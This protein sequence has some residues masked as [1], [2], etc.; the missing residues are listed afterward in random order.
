MA[1]E[2]INLN[3]GNPLLSITILCSFCLALLFPGESPFELTRDSSLAF[4]Q[5]SQALQNVDARLWQDPFKVIEEESSKENKPD[6]TIELDQ[7]KNYFTE[8]ELKSSTFEVMMITLSGGNRSEDSESRMR[9]RFAV[10]SALIHNEYL[11]LDNK[12]IGAINPNQSG[13]GLKKRIPFEI[14]KKKEDED[15][16]RIVLWIDED[17]LNAPMPLDNNKNNSPSIASRLLEINNNILEALNGHDQTK[18]SE[19]IVIGPNSSDTMQKITREGV[20]NCQNPDSKGQSI[21]FL[22][23][24]ATASDEIIRGKHA[25]LAIKRPYN[26]DDE[27]IQKL[28]EELTLEGFKSDDSIAIFKE[29]DTLYGRSMETYVR[30]K[31]KDNNKIFISYFKGVNDISSGNEKK[32][33]EKKDTANASIEHSFG[34][35]QIDYIRREVLKLKQHHPDLKAIGV[36]GNEIND[37]LLIIE[38]IR[39]EFPHIRIITTDLDAEYLHPDLFKYTHN[40]IIASSFG[41]NPEPV[42]PSA[43]TQESQ[44][45]QNAPTFRDSYQTAFYVTVDHAIKKILG[46]YLDD[47][48]FE[49]KLYEV[50]KGEFIDLNYHS[51][52]K[53]KRPENTKLALKFFAVVI[54]SILLISVLSWN[55]RQFLNRN[56]KSLIIIGLVMMFSISLYIFSTSLPEPFLLLSGASTWPSIILRLLVIVVAWLAIKN[57]GIKSKL[58]KLQYEY[59]LTES[60]NSRMIYSFWDWLLV[61]KWKHQLPSSENRVDQLWLDYKEKVFSTCFSF[62]GYVFKDNYSCLWRSVCFTL[63]IFFISILIFFLL[64]MPETPTRG[65]GLR[66]LQF[67]ITLFSVFALD[68]LIVWNFQN[69]RTC[70]LLIEKIS[71]IQPS[72]WNNSPFRKKYA[73]LSE[74]VYQ[75]WAD[76]NFVAEITDIFEPLI[77]PPLIGIGLMVL[78][79]NSIFDDWDMPNHLIMTYLM[80]IIFTIYAEIHQLSSARQIR[81]KA[82]QSLK[83]MLDRENIKPKTGKNDTLKIQIEQT[84]ANIENISKGAFLPW[85]KTQTFKS[86][87][88]IGTAISIIQYFMQMHN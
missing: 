37:K 11:P 30:D 17:A 75:Q 47:V 32:E 86:I 74:S 53:N 7:L 12:H 64:G 6:T 20:Y 73:F 38:A 63:I 65:S 21:T 72:G 51:D 9:R 40:I 59:G 67:C 39:K 57:L 46:N 85:Y 16:K 4:P 76:I 55:A 41:L 61:S 78:A 28:K 58:I 69:T 24:A 8:S 50:A 42:T 33:S 70:N 43:Q 44:E 88:G 18:K 79:R 35:N 52:R 26:K 10:T 31:F 34:K 29:L 54:V 49:A 1:A 82:V 36:F 23:A 22:P 56:W 13:T 62:K 60:D 27:L 68:F 81:E 71:M 80:M 14:Y 45:S 5:K 83:F 48:T 77:W 87:G 2:K 84:I 15:Q 25:E 3:P 66:D 19:L